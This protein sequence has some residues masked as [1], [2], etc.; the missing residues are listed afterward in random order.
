MKNHAH[1]RPG[2]VEH[3]WAIVTERTANRVKTALEAL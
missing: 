3:L 1:L 2:Y